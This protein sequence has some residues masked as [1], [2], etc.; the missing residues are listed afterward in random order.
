LRT[1]NIDSASKEQTM[2]EAYT[3]EV[4]HWCFDSKALYKDLNKF[5][6]ISF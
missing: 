6:E 5:T 2:I 3:A 4:I 1:N